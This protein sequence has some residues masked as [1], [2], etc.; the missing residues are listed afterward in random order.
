MIIL[1]TSVR[2][3]SGVLL[4]SLFENKMMEVNNQNLLRTTK[5]YRSEHSAAG[6][7][8]GAPCESHDILRLSES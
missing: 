3:E 8:V 4:M 5:H 2:K 1:H 7:E 6:A